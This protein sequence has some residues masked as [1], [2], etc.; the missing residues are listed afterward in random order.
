LAFENAVCV[1]YLTEKFWNP[2]RHLTVPIILSREILNEFD[3]I[4]ANS[5]IAAS[6]FSSAE[7]LAKFLNR[8]QNDETKYLRFKL[9]EYN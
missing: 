7:E 4:P 9:L 1:D 8:I 6:D 3:G 2:L 5:F